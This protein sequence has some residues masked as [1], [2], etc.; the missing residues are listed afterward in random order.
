MNI[1]I[2]ATA[3]AL[4]VAP[5]LR[6]EIKR[7]LFAVRRI[8]TVFCIGQRQFSDSPAGLR[9]S[10]KL[11]ETV[12]AAFTYGGKQDGSPVIG[13]VYDPVCIAMGSDTSR[14]PA[15]YRHGIYIIITV[16]VAGECNAAS[17]GRE[18]RENLHACR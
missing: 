8:A 10:I 13:P 1:C 2:P 17:V 6:A 3:V 14:H 11:V 18:F 4:P 9:N 16:V 5:H 15:R 12:F 7:H